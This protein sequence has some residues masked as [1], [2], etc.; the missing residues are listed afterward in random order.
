MKPKQRGVSNVSCVVTFL[1][2][3]ETK[4][5]LI[6]VM[7]KTLMYRDQDKVKAPAYIPPVFT[8]SATL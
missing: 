1:V 6:E 7:T 3:V 2:S 4:T 8:S 5:T